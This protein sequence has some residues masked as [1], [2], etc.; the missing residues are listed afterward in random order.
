MIKICTGVHNNEVQYDRATPKVM[1]SHILYGFV[2]GNVECID[3]EDA[4]PEM[5]A[6]ERKLV[7]DQLYKQAERVYKLLG[8]GT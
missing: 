4:Y 2:Q 5:T 8:Y 6:R 1:A 3:L 7:F